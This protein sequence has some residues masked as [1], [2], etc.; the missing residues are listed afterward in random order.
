MK[1]ILCM[2]L[3]ILLAPSAHAA[4]PG[5]MAKK[6]FSVIET[7]NIIKYLNDHSCQFR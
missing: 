4:L 6:E 1:C 7:Q 2:S 5:D 3:F